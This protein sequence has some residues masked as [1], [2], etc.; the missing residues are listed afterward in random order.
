[1]NHDVV[2]MKHRLNLL[3][4]ILNCIKDNEEENSQ[5]QILDL[6]KEIKELRKK[7]KANT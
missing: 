3:E 2:Q 5:Q 6:E 7:I 4:I 1:M